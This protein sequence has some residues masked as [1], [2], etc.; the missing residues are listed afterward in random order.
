M[1]ETFSTS[2]ALCLFRNRHITDRVQKHSKLV[3]AVEHH[4]QAIKIKSKK[5]TI[6]K[7]KI[8]YE[9]QTTIFFDAQASRLQEKKKKT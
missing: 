2:E 9:A 5:F 7:L 4:G 8:V 1:T 6:V 3:L